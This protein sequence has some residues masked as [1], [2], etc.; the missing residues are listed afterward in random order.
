MPKLPSVSDM[1]SACHLQKVLTY[2]CFFGHDLEKGTWLFG[3]LPGMEALKRVMS[4]KARDK[5][6]AIRA[7]KNQRRK[8]PKVYYIKKGD[9]VHG[10]EL[11]AQTATYPIRFCTQ[12]IKIWAEAAESATFADS[13]ANVVAS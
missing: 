10:T 3:N 7:R 12:L 13:A 5:Y 6:A 1:I 8:E 2:L 9:R 4:K 11:M